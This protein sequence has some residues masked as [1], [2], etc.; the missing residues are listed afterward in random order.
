MPAM[1]ASRSALGAT[2]AG[3]L[4]P[5]SS[6]TRAMF[7]LAYSSTARPAATL[8]VSV[9]IATCGWVHSAAAASCS[10]ARMLTTPGG[11]SASSTACAISIALHGVWLLGRTTTV[12]PVISAGAILRASV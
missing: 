9:I 3:V 1:A 5:S 7:A 8:P 11:R 4:P 6:D 12:L 2:M 10:M